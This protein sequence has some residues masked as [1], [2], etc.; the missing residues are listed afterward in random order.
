MNFWNHRKVTMVAAVTMGL[1]WPMAGRAQDD[2][3]CARVKIEIKQE[4]TLE[5]QA[6]DAEMKI[7]NQLD[8]ASLTE[9]K[10]VVKV[11]DDQGVPVLVSDDPDNLAAKF[12]LRVSSKENIAA[13]DGTGVVAPKTTS[14][15]NWLLIP[16][17]GS[18]G[19]SPVS[20]THL[21]LPTTE[22]V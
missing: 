16:A 14:T 1:A 15:I 13:V 17:P 20:Y 4:L 7:S 6:F 2:S 18:A 19:S 22:R 3:V 10:V 9:V 21:T 11:T 12:F 5:R 8:A